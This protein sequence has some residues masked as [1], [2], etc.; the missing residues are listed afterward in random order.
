MKIRFC[1][2]SSA[3]F[4]LIILTMLWQN[5]IAFLRSSLYLPT[6]AQKI[7]RPSPSFS[8]TSMRSKSDKGQDIVKTK[9]RDVVIPLEK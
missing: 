5:S 4:I 8:L 3:V 6:N 7:L 9:A 1:Q 2:I